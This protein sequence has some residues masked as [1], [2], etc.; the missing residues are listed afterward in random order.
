MIAMKQQR[1]TPPHSTVGPAGVLH[2]MRV[3]DFGQYL[4]GPLL[5]M[6][7]GD[8]GAEVV[9]VDPPGGPR[10][11]HPV[12]C[13]L[14]RG[15][16]RITLDLADPEARVAAQR[17]IDD[18]DVVIE[19]FRPGVAE[20]LG[21]GPRQ[22]LARN[23]R[24]VYCSL[25]GFAH[26]DPRAGVRAWEGVVCAAAGI[27]VSR[28]QSQEDDPVYNAIPY[29]SSFGV[30]VAAHSVL[31]ALIARERDGLGQWV[32]VPLFDALF[33]AIGHFGLR[34]VDGPPPRTPAHFGAT[35][36]TSP[37]GGFYRCADGHWIHLCLI[38]ARHLHAF[39]KRFFLQ[40]WIDDGMADTSRVGGVDTDTGLQGSDPEVS[41]RA[42]ARFAE[43]MSTKPAAEWERIINDELGCP[44]A[45][46]LS[47]E[48]WLSDAH[49]EAVEAVVQVTDPQAGSTR[50]LG[51]PMRLC[52]TPP[53]VAGPRRP[54]DADR[55]AILREFEHARPLG[56]V[57]EPARAS[58][59]P[60]EGVRVVDVSQVLAGPTATRILAEYGADVVKVMSPYDGQ[61][62]AHAYTNNGKRS[63]MLDLKTPQGRAIYL[64]L[65]RDSDVVNEN[66][67][68]GTTDR[69]GIGE[70]TV[71]SSNPEVVYA[72]LSAYGW[73]EGGRSA[74]RGREELG[75]AITGMEL[76]W[77]GSDAS[78]RMQPYALN[79]YGAGNWAAAAVLAALLHRLRG[80]QGQHV[81]TSL[82][83][84]ATF[85]QAP[86]M[87]S[88]P[89][90]TVD[91]PGGQ[92]TLGADQFNRLYRTRDR[93]IYIACGRAQRAELSAVV[94]LAA[95]RLVAGALEQ[96]F[97]ERPADQWVA[98]LQAAGIGAHVLL[99]TEEVMEDPRVRRRGLSIVKEMP[100]AGA[101][102]VLGPSPRLARTPPQATRGCTPPGSDAPSVLAEIG[103]DADIRDLIDRGVIHQRLADGVSLVGRV[104]A[105]V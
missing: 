63:I 95:D 65:A 37:Q 62:M 11:D 13:A 99:T 87:V 18:A 80:G 55:A 52:G 54:L 5:A 102:R 23:S 45:A 7:L 75:Q 6:V 50:Q 97:V 81:H 93:W 105:A 49:A 16:R 98:D 66:F 2:G 70:A 86:F 71:R 31:A 53:R 35:G 67:S 77:G 82:A 10:W 1:H 42:R 19:N 68:L 17:L 34:M 4:A 15:K 83:H 90:G 59:L 56:P 85:H 57:T 38:Q 47:S 39:A 104:R 44:A 28:T 64:R 32:E 69:L 3:I 61:I 14:Q 33:E 76:R 36:G 73:W 26:D 100:G 9:R 25:P 94:D 27:Y 92:H 60:L 46:C 51:F 8:L 41:A 43:L 78:P 48:E 20:R 29:A 79:D 74:W 84:A 40:E 91:A 72:S 30:A 101:A 89:H 58:T 103:Y 22:S 96:R 21:I 24:L 88:T 12:D